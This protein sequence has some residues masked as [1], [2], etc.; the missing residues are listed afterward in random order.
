MLEKSFCCLYSVMF[1]RTQLLHGITDMHIYLQS[2]AVEVILFCS[3]FY[4]NRFMLL[5]TANEL[6]Q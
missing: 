2:E 3:L 5:T 1:Y 6:L 4:S